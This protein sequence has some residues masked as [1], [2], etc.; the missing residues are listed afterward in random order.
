MKDSKE[1]G[2]ISLSTYWTGVVLDTVISIAGAAIS[3]GFLKAFTSLKSKYGK[4]KA[5]LH[6][7]NMAKKYAIKY[8]GASVGCAV[9]S[10]LSVALT[11]IS[12]VAA[13]GAAI[14][15]YWS[16]HDCKPSK[17]TIDLLNEGL[18]IFSQ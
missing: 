15:N 16:K 17:G 3:G 6:F 8:F 11:V 4:E 18:G 14:A 10:I 9:A 1:G 13:P 5:A 12:I 2:G 7:G